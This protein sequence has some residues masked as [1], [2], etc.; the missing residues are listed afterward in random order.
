MSRLVSA[1]ERNREPLTVQYEGEYEDNGKS[2]RGSQ[3][4]AVRPAQGHQP[5]DL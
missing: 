1:Y 2:A 4:D 5:E 3:E